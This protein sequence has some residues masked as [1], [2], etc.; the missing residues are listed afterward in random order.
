MVE[1]L[2]LRFHLSVVMRL[3]GTELGQA[4]QSA[5]PPPLRRSFFDALALW[6]EDGTDTSQGDAA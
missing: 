5:L 2:Q 6:C 4:V 3:L 1:A